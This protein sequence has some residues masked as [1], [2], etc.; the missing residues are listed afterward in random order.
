MCV[1][2]GIA[3]VPFLFD[4]LLTFISYIGQFMFLSIALYPLV[5]LT[6]FLLFYS[7]FHFGAGASHLGVFPFSIYIFIFL[8]SLV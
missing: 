7:P 6:M 8:S 2:C 5:L 3:T 1:I 4:L